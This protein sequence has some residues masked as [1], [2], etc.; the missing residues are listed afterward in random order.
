M[1]DAQSKAKKVD[2]AKYP[3]KDKYYPNAKN[4]DSNE[5]FN[6]FN[7]LVIVLGCG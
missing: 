5:T 7:D 6:L 4:Y 1:S 2:D 3:S